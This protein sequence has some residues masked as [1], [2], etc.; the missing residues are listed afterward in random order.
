MS[1]VITELAHI[2]LA[3]VDL[4]LMG[5]EAKKDHVA[6]PVLQTLKEPFPE[7]G[8]L[9][10]TLPV[11]HL[12]DAVGYAMNAKPVHYVVGFRRAKDIG[13]LESGCDDCVQLQADPVSSL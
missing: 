12:P 5:L 4:K 7:L 3:Q 8:V 10:I 2:E 9:A 13:L 1:E 6:G 11:L